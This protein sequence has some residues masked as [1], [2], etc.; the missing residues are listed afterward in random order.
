M[1]VDWNTLNEADNETADIDFKA[2]FDTTSAEDWCELIKDIVAMANSSGGVVVFGVNDDG[3]PSTADLASVQNLDP[4]M[5]VDKI[6]KYTG[7]QFA[8]FSVSSGTR[9]TASVVALTVSGSSMPERAD[10]VSPN[11][12]A[13]ARIVC[14]V[15]RTI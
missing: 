8:G 7:Q 3:S 11:S 5:I 9:R 13:K 12:W 2:G 4:A 6:K 14:D 10:G 15:S 1:G